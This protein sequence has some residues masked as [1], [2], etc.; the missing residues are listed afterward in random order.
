[1]VQAESLC[2]LHDNLYFPHFSEERDEAWRCDLRQG[3][4][5]FI[6]EMEQYIELKS[7]PTPVTFPLSRTPYLSM[8]MASSGGC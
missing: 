6:A 2:V 7:D 5:A 4:Q 8:R 3:A 1:M